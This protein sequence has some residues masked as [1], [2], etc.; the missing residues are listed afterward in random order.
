VVYLAVFCHIM[1]CVPQG[2]SSNSGNVA[3]NINR[4]AVVMERCWNVV[5]GVSD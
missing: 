2:G 5:V 4:L 1:C 3:V